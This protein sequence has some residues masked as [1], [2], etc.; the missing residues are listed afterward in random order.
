MSNNDL[1]PKKSLGQHFLADPNTARRIAKLGLAEVDPGQRVIE[2]GAGLGSLTV[3]LAAY[4]AKVVAVETDSTLVKILRSVVESLDVRVVHAN[5][6]KLDWKELLADESLPVGKG[7][8]DWLLIANLPYNIATL[9]VIKLLEEV[10]EIS[11]MLVM[12]QK[13]VGDRLVASVGQ[14]GFGA[15]SLKVA[16]WADAKLVGKVPSNVFIPP[17]AVSSVLVSITRRSSAVLSLDDITYDQ[18]FKVVYAGFATRRKM[19][20][21]ALDGIVPPRAYLLADISPQSRAE[22]LSLMD[23]YRLVSCM[24]A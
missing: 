2:I 13:E 7:P 1:K 3:A 22:Q 14:D 9:L 4:G 6:L 17:P 21:R 23:W 12:V 19:L 11:K 15:V 8:T 24:K 20:R 18:L 5:A 16:Y 10:R